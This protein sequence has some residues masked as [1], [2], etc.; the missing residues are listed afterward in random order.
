MNNAK[1]IHNCKD[2]IITTDGKIYKTAP[3]I[4]EI[5]VDKLNR[6]NLIDNNGKTIRT[7]LKSIYRKT[8]NKE[9]CVDNIEDIKGEQWQE[10]PNTS[11]KYYVS[12]YGRIKSYCGYSAIILKTDETEFGY[13]VVKINNK[14]VK[15]HRL[16][17]FA[18]CNDKEIENNSSV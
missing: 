12:N 7:T 5:K 18:F 13:L 2:Y 6:I 3:T 9:F 16:V 4:K 15:V 10:I 8:F 17:A 1:T 14:N 11:G